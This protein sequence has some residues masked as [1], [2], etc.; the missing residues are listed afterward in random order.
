MM[1][2]VL[3]RIMVMMVRMIARRSARRIMMMVVMVAVMM[4][5]D[6]N[7]RNCQDY[8]TTKTATNH[9]FSAG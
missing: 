7:R 9:P 4:L 8:S 3:G 5:P 1:M 6:W 2:V